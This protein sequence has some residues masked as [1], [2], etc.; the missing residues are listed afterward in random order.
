MASLKV[1]VDALSQPCRA[2][3]TLLEVNKIPYETCVIKLT[4]GQS[5]DLYQE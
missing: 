2:V 4:E 3:M 5:I 1:F